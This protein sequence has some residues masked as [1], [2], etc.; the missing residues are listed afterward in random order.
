MKLFACS[1]VMEERGAVSYRAGSCRREESLSPTARGPLMSLLE[2]KN[3]R[4][5]VGRLPYHMTDQDLADLF[6]QYGQVLSASVIVDRDTG[7]SKGFGFVEMSTV[8]E[9]RAAMNT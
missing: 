5:Y 4:L 8:Q 6:G 3:V 2:K 9:A 1:S 7:R